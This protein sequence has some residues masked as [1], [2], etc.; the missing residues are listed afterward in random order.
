MPARADDDQV[1]VVRL[2]KGDDLTDRVTAQQRRRGDELVLRSRRCRLVEERPIVLA[3]LVW[4][5]TADSAETGRGH[6]FHERHDVDEDQF[7]PLFGRQLD[8][9]RDR[10]GRRA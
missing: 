8:R 3:D 6:D 10:L 4:E 7:G 9:E 5:C 1:D 2:G